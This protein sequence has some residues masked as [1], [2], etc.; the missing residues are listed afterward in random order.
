MAQHICCQALIFVNRE[1]IERTVWRVRPL[2]SCLILLVHRHFDLRLADC[3]LWWS[4]FG[5]HAG[6]CVGFF[7]KTFHF[8][9]GNRSFMGQKERKKK[10][11]DFIVNYTVKRCLIK[12]TIR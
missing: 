2:R 7:S 4:V 1:P 11:R 10:I 3:V 8:L 9:V 5:R 12:V 6:A